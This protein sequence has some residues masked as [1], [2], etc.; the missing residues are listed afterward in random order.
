MPKVGDK[1]FDYTPEGVA[2]AKKYAEATGEN[3]KSAYKKGGKVKKPT[4]KPLPMKPKWEK[5]PLT[6]KMVK[7]KPKIN[8]GPHR[9]HIPKDRCQTKDQQIDWVN[10]IAGKNWGDRYEFT[11]SLKEACQDWGTW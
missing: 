6:G 2:K 4:R 5:D 10:Q 9:P 7:V 8:K 1:H 11:K 3:V